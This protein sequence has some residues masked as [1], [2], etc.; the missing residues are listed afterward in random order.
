M[1]DQ[2]LRPNAPRI[3]GE[4]ALALGLGQTNRLE[5]TKNISADWN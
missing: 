3:L 1:L 5:G 4:S 2:Q